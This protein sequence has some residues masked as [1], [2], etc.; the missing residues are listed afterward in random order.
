MVDIYV[1]DEEE[2]FEPEVTEM[3]FEGLILAQRN[4]ST[5]QIVFTSGIVVNVKQNDI[6]LSFN[7]L[8]PEH[9]KGL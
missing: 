9:F 3:D 8:L 6:A 1:N 4:D 2:S 5:I 7:V